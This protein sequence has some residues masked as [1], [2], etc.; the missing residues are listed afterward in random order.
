MQP[1]SHLSRR[2]MKNNTLPANLT[3]SIN[4]IVFEGKRSE[5]W[6]THLRTKQNLHLVMNE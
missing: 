5:Y 6:L 4:H 3:E 2:P 1:L